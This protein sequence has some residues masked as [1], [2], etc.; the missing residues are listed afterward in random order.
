M[1]L[2]SRSSKVV[3]RDGARQVNA[4]RVNISL[5]PCLRE[6]S[7]TVVTKKGYAGLSDYVQSYLRR[8]AAALGMQVFEMAP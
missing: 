8:D 6:V 1:K 2:R 5:P 4:K 3:A 7:S